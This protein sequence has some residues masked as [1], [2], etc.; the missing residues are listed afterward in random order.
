LLQN[1]TKAYPKFFEVSILSLYKSVY[2]GLALRV[3]KLA[4]LR[5]CRGEKK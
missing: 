1:L 2:S 5:A 3:R 4:I